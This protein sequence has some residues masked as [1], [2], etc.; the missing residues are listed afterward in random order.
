MAALGSCTA[1]TVRAMARRYGWAI[2]T[3]SVTTRHEKLTSPTGRIDRFDREI[4][5]AGALTEEQRL[6][7]TQAAEACPV[8]MTLRHPSVV[9][10]KLQPR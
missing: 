8:S 3:V 6:H 5:V 9:T 4:T 7:L 10:V 1:M 2:G